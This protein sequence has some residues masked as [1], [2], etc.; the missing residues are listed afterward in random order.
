[1]HDNATSIPVMQHYQIT[2]LVGIPERFQHCNAWRVSPVL[3]NLLCLFRPLEYPNNIIQRNLG[4]RLSISVLGDLCVPVPAPLYSMI[5][6]NLSSWF[7]QAPSPSL[8]NE[9]L[10]VTA[11]IAM[12]FIRPC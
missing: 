5:L 11:H 6:L 9:G 7:P 4:K 8:Q 2:P 10:L 3:E 12:P 1:M